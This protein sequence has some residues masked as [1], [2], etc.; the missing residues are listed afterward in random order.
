MAASDEWDW[1]FTD[2]AERDFDGLDSH[3]QERLV[4]K[5]D[6]IVTDQWRD[7]TD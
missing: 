7:P 5:L 3:E 6:A 4:S 1:R 2:P